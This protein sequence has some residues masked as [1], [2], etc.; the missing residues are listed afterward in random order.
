MVD[1]SAESCY[2]CHSANEPL[3][4]IS[5]TERTRIFRIDP[6][7]N[8][9]L[10]IITPIYNEKSCWQAKCHAHPKDQRVLGVLDVSISLA[11]IDQTIVR[12]EWEIVIFAIIAIIAVGLLIGYFVRNGFL[13]P[14]NDLLSATN[15]VSR[16]I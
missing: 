6:D 13:Y 7:S 12:S 3:E 11:D 4:K 2:A 9:V 10:G 15:Q 8:R 14:V 16:E 5:I 1:K